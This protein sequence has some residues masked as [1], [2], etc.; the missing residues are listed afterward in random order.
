M[1][2]LSGMNIWCELRSRRCFFFSPPPAAVLS[3]ALGKPLAPRL[4]DGSTGGKPQCAGKA[5]TKAENPAYAGPARL[6]VAR[7]SGIL[8]LKQSASQLTT[9][10][11]TDVPGGCTELPLGCSDS[12]PHQYLSSLLIHPLEDRCRVHQT[13][14]PFHATVCNPC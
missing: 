4:A 6:A 11:R 3:T 2:C 14:Q 12:V 13:L 1:I 7:P 5:L 8:L 10:G 9:S